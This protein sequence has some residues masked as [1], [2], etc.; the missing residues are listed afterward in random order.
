MDLLLWEEEQQRRIA[1]RVIADAFGS[2]EDKVRKTIRPLATT[3]LHIPGAVLDGLVHLARLR[4]RAY[5]DSIQRK[6]V[7]A[8]IS[9]SKAHK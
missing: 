7:R 4:A 1:N 9:R 3:L 2:D 8:R 6:E 5:Q